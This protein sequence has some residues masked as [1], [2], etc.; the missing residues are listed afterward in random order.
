MFCHPNE[1]HIHF[2]EHIDPAVHCKHMKK[3]ICGIPQCTTHQT[4]IWPFVE[5]YHYHPD[6]HPHEVQVLGG[7]HTKPMPDYNHHH[8]VPEPKC[9]CHHHCEP[10]HIPHHHHIDC[11]DICHHECRREPVKIVDPSKDTIH[12]FVCGYDS[13]RLR[14]S[15]VAHL[16]QYRLNDEYEVNI[17]EH[18]K[19]NFCVFFR[20]RVTDKCEVLYLTY[21]EICDIECTLN[22]IILPKLG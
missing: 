3:D 4:L 10:H 1:N 14:C 19:G 15:E 11:N 13:F 6:L 8:I 18:G 21:E 17:A 20:S 22:K 7:C 12:D 5:H 9:D 16:I 2:C